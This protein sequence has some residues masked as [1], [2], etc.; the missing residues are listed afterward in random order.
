MAIVSLTT[1]VVAHDSLIELRR[2]LPPLLAELGEQ[3]ELI[4][5]DNASSDD[6]ALELGCLA[7][8]ARLISLKENVGFAGGANAGA[9]A[10][11]GQLLVLLN[12]DAMVSTGWADAIRSPWESEWAGWMA[13]VTLDDEQLINTSGGVLHF[14]GFGWAGQVGQPLA[15]APRAPTEVS[16]LS[17]ACLAI[18]LTL[19]D[20]LR[21]F[22]EHFFMYCED[23][24][25]SLRLRLSGKR[26][27]VVPDAIVAHDYKFAQGLLKWRLLER[28]RWATM[29][30][31]YPRLLLAA[32]MP[33]LLATEPAVWAVATRNGWSRM[34]LLAT[35]DVLRAL[36][37]L[38]A[39]RREIQSSASISAMDFAAQLTARLDSP[40]FGA[41]GRQPM[42]E[43]GLELYWRTVL[44]LLRQ[45][46]SPAAIQVPPPS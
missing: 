21:G 17:G 43:R 36:P 26:L 38:L 25:L 35:L 44:W 42:L 19:W 28:N 15:Q 9:A 11:Q 30:R 8:A 29:I 24:D 4:V 20:D 45:T 40:Y 6:L 1:V 5:V 18:P 10:A 3:D 2:S 33:A 23:V 41:V 32:V 12:P 7:P 31:T 39:E 27:A 13:L 34:K 16:F 46:C 22:P 37:R 14:T